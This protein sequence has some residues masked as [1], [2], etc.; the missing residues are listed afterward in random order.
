MTKICSFKIKTR[1]RA[2]THTPSRNTDSA[3]VIE[4]NEIEEN[5]NKSVSSNPD[6][7][8]YFV[9]FIRILSV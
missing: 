5:R 6:I 3:K 7:A 8:F 2:H 1:A 4:L 9:I